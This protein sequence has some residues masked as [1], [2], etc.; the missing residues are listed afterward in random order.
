MASP[1]TFDFPAKIINVPLPDVNLD[2]QFLLNSIREAEDDITPGMAYP[3]IADA[4]GKQDLGNN[5][6]VGITVVLLD[7]WRV[8]FA[9]RPGTATVSCTITGGNFVGEAGANPVAPSAYTQVTTQ[10][11]S[12]ATIITPQSDTNLVYLV[13]SLRN[14]HPAFGNV[15]YWDPYGGL[16][17]NTGLTPSAAVKTFAYAHSL[18]IA[19][20]SNNDVIFCR[21]SDPSG[22]TVV[23][24]VLNITNH[25]LKVRGPGNSVQIIPSSTS[26]PTINIDADNVEVSGFYIETADTGTQ[27]AITVTGNNILLRDSWIN[28]TRGHGI[29]ASSSAR[30]RILTSVIENC[31]GSGTGNGINLGNTTTQSLISKC[32]I[33][34]CKNGI[35]LSG[36]GLT[37]N[38]IENCLVFKNI[39]KGVNIGA[40]VLRTT[41]RSANTITNNGSVEADNV[42]NSGTDTYQEAPS[43]GESAGTIAAAVWDEAIASHTDAGS[44]GK[45]LKDT[46]LKATLASIK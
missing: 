16:D 36:T 3:K 38:V 44:A 23:D 7:G 32:L 25:N 34:N 39:T 27:N 14:S 24:E 5:V 2:L 12:S 46:K 41:L 45:I 17:T 19:T 11:S 40:N 28:N 22:T 10:Q 4:F 8:K 29:S 21:S 35:V 31:G 6:L 20:P 33:S 9:D 30:L 26:S 15:Y 37:E 18:S 1:L 43:G 13:E 42:A